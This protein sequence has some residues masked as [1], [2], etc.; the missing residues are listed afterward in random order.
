MEFQFLTIFIYERRISS[1]YSLTVITSNWNCRWGHFD[2][3]RVSVLR[4]HIVF[5]DS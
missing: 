2:L 5:T 4:I 1:T 3:W